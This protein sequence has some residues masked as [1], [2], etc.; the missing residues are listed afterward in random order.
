MKP[1]LLAAA[2]LFTLP[3]AAQI[4]PAPA[5]TEGEGPHAQLILRGLTVVNGTGAPAY[6]PVDIVIEGDR[7]SEVR[8]VGNPGVPINPARRPQLREGGREMDLSGHYAMPGIVD[9][10]GHI[11]GREQGVDAEYV[12]KL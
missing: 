2:L 7:I 9:M 1:L 12:Y 6:G 11:G 5:R 8:T 4:A 3:A 10:H